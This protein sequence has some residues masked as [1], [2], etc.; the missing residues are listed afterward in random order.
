MRPHPRAPARVMATLGLVIAMLTSSLEA[1][2]QPPA[3][4]DTVRPRAATVSPW[5]GRRLT[6]HRYTAYAIPPLFLAQG[7]LGKQLYRDVDTPDGPAEWVRPAHR[8]GAALI[9][10]AFA[11]NVTTGVLNL[12]ADRHEPEG[13]VVRVLHGTSMMVA[14][15]G[16]TYAGVKLA[17]E[18]RTSM[19]K[20]RE[21]RTVAIGS[22]ALT[23]VSGVAMWLVNR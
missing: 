18:A 21:H 12:W 13:R 2:Q 22:M 5:H 3:A 4:S 23:T 14:A 7:L 16:F 19:D 1:Q 6:I 11:T 15:A 20:R 9:G 17:D 10:A 8:I